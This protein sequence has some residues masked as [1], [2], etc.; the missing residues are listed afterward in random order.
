MS[1]ALLVAHSALDGVAI[2]FG[3][4]V[5][6]AV[7]VAAAI[8]VVTHDFCDGMNTASMMLVAGHSVRRSFAMLVAA[9]AAPVV[10]AC[11]ASMVAVPKIVL[12]AYLGSFA[13]FLL[14]VAGA[15]LLP[16]AHSGGTRRRSAWLVALTLSG[17]VLSF[18]FS[19][20]TGGV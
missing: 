20:A 5:S 16:E 9:A 18:L 15:D 4:Q 7:G 2:G 13:G 12:L 19:L 1:A 17:V 3:F 6:D 14:Y 10:G 11:V 8:A